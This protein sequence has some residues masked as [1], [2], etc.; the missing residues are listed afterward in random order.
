MCDAQ[1]E[2]AWPWR[3]GPVVLA[4]EDGAGAG[5][6]DSGVGR[7]RSLTDDDLEELKGCMDLGSICSAAEQQTR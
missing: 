1:W 2:V 3:A 6:R 4:G 7:A 5:A